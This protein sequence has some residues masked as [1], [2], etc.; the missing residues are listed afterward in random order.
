MTEDVPNPPNGPKLTISTPLSAYH[1][2]PTDLIRLFNET[3]EQSEGVHLVRG[4]DEPVY[5]PADEHHRF[6]RVV[7]AHGFF[8]SA[9]HEIAHW[10]IAG[11]ARRLLIDYGYW[12]K[13]DGRDRR[14][15]V[16][17]EKVEARPQAIEWAFSIAAGSPFRVSV[18]NLS[19]EPV[20]QEGFRRRVHDQL[21][22]YAHEGFP[23]RAQRFIGVLCEAYGRRF[24]VPPISE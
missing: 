20:D 21:L 17:F 2:D 7:F 19:G 23:A 11:P 8:A 6:H 4:D 12:Y 9:L 13:P 3:F 18:D 5:L 10:C 15:Q 14:E 22:R 16:E 24:Q 1:H